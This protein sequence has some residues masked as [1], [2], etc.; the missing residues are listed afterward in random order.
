MCVLLGA[1]A[2]PAYAQEATIVGTVTD[3]SGAAVPNAT[4]TITSTET[5]QVRQITSN[6]V[7]QYVVPDLRIGHYTVRVQAAGFKVTE[8]KDVA[9]AV[10]DRLRMDFK[11]EIGTSQEQ[12]TVEA[13]PIAVQADSGEVSDVITGQQITQLAT[14]GRSLYS[15]AALTPGASS[16]M[17]DSQVAVPVGGDANVS[18]NGNRVAH[19]IYLIDGGENLDRG[20]AGTISV[21]PSIDAIAEFRTL[22]SNYSADYGLSSAGTLSMVFKSGTKDLHATL[23]EFLRNDKLDARNFFDPATKRER[24]LNVFGFNIGG[25]VTFGKLYNKDRDKT[26]FFY[27]M[28]WRRQ[29]LGGALNQQVPLTSTYGGN[30]GSTTIYAPYTCQVNSSIASAFATAG[31][32][33][34]GCTPDGNP[35]PTK[36][37]AFKNNTIPS[38]L[39]DA[40]AQAL[41]N[42]KIF[43]A[44]TTGNYFRGGNNAPTNVRDQIVRMDHRFSD[45]VSVFGHFVA[46][47]ILQTYGTT[48]WSGDNVPSIGNT[49]GNP[50]YSGVI[51]FVQSISPSLVNE[52]AFNYNGNRINILPI[53]TYDRSGVS[54]PKVFSG[55]N[56]LSRLP[57]IQLGGST[58]TN[59]TANWVPWNNKADDYQIRDDI[60]WV[61]GSHQI[62]IGASWAIY[63]KIQDLFANTQG[64]FN[65]N[66]FYTGNDFAD[67]LLG[68][69]ASYNENSLKDFGRWDN[70]SWAA[71]VQDNWRVNRRLTLNLGLRWDGVP[72]TYEEN[73]RGSGFYPF[74]WDA[75]KKAVLSSSGSI[76]PSSPGLITSSNPALAGV[77][78]YFNGMGIAGQNGVPEGMVDNHWAAFGPR[79]GFA[80]DLTGAGKTVVRGGAGVMYERVQGNDMYQ[81]AGNPPFTSSLNLSNV[82]LSNPNKSIV[83]GATLSGPIT[84]NSI[85]GWDKNDYKLPVSYQFSM[86]VQQQL[87]AKNVLELAYVGTQNRHQSNLKELNLP[88]PS[89]LASIINNGSLYNTLVPYQGFNSILIAANNQ[90][91]HYNSL[92]AS[93]RGEVTQDLTLQVAYTL[94]KAVDPGNFEQDGGDLCRVSNPFD[95]SYDDGPS[96]FDRTHIFIANF[97][98]KLPILKNSSDKVLKSVLGGWELSGIVTE[99]TGVPQNVTLGG[100]AGGNGLPNST[101]RPNLSGGISYPKTADSWFTGS[102]SAPALGQWGN[103]PK[104]NVRGPGRNN[105]N[106]SLFK[107]FTLNEAR[108]SRFELRFEGF[109]VFNHT[110]FNGV[111]T[112]FTAGNFG[113]ITSAFD[114]RDI[115]IGAKLYF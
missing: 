3:P 34:S 60:S 1:I 98:Y 16:I 83:T 95:R 68:Y 100:N 71:Y 42:K 38:S 82:Y 55:E 11:L 74:L 35:D 14:N 80:Y 17:G 96:L 2:I 49:F 4:I 113:K 88:H 86:G 40:N 93:L 47:S 15:L 5:G 21:M 92:Q 61:K 53:G 78:F 109:N 10:G 20:G 46:E 66:G 99:E 13:S 110:Q 81:S 72:H 59:Y 65:F 7:G 94:S 36:Q 24:R 106:L 48:M 18:F 104:R 44:A 97:V 85:S 108:G 43:P 51:H 58:G 33:M 26:F 9:L 30:F 50:S 84:I 45:K 67:F 31:Q 70:V 28:E 112:S 64:G 29:V 6:S 19:N 79:V 63:K 54:I 25:P 52:T 107:S 12:I 115:Q 22:S 114:A 102:F 90:N 56:A 75:S 8:H 101:N 62:K 73:N 103:T 39:L 76:D 105:F 69:A 23:W 87:G 37:V 77:K 41:L 32:A 111:S 27:N 89:L 57:S 91:A